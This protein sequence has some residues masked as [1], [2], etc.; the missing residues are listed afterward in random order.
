MF[1]VPQLKIQ[2][3]VQKVFETFNNA[4]LKECIVPN[5]VQGEKVVCCEIFKTIP[6]AYLSTMGELNFKW[7]S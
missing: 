1:Y 5:E 7:P 3:N 4:F 2:R 6:I